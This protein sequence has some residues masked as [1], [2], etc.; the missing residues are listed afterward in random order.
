[1]ELGISERRA[2]QVIGQPRT[3]QRYRTKKPEQD[4]PLAKRMHQLSEEN[5]RAGYRMICELLRREGWSV[6]RKRVHRLWKQ[7]GL[8]VPQKQ[9]KRRRLGSSDN[10]CVRMKASHRNH[11]WS[12]DFLFDTTEDGRQVKFM[13]ILDEY[14]RQCLTIDVSRS[15]T[16]RRVIEEL[17]RLFREH[18]P[19]ENLRSDNGP[20]FVAEALKVYLASFQVATRYI[21]PGAPWQNGYVESFNATF[22][23]ELLDRELFSTV[24]E[25]TVLSAQ[26]RQKYNTYRPHSRL[27]YMTPSA[28]TARCREQANIIPEPVEALT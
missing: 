11:G 3:T 10:G 23:D 25:A 1:V 7:A 13:P 28:F 18:G 2:C 26:Y 19:P 24:L 16:S 27:D 8:Q 14:T 9:R 20:E 5:P 12:I 17:E 6:N 15:I 4:R 21:E 22:R